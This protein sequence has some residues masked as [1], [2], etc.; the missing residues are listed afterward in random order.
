MVTIKFTMKKRFAFLT[1]ILVAFSNT[2]VYAQVDNN[3]S[4]ESFEKDLEEFRSEFNEFREKAVKE[5]DEYAKA[6][7]AEYME[8]VSS[9]KDMWGE[10]NVAED[11]KTEWV[12]YGKDLKSRSVVDFENGK[13]DV[14]ILLDDENENDPA[15][16]NQRLT[17]AIKDLLESRGTTCPYDSKV[18]KQ[19]PLSQTPILEGIVDFSNYNIQEKIANVD[20]SSNII[21]LKPKKKMPP[22]PV[23]KGK[24]LETSKNNITANTKSKAN[25]AIENKK[26]A[27][28]EE[29]RIAAEKKIKELEVE[30]I[31]EEKNVTIPAVN[32]TEQIAEV[33]AEQSV[34]SSTTIKGNDNK[35]RTI[36][37]IEMALVSDNLSKNA[38][39][40]K[41]YVKQYSQKFNIEQPLIFA[42][43]EQESSFNPK[44]KSWVPAYGL[45]QL[46]PT[47]GGYDAYRYVYKNDWVPTQS[48]L[49]VPHQNIELGTAYLRILMNQFAN[50]TNPDC[51][52]LCVIA[53]YNT[54]AGNVSRA[55]TGNTNIKKAIPLINKYSY[56]QLYQHLTN[57]LSTDEARKYVSGVS[58][59]REKYLK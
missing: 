59:R 50:V 14:E 18:D 17:T 6:M 28:L 37:K 58:K 22:T 46:V 48:Y 4:K 35:E 43:M 33:I 29:E 30:E 7:Y 47:S 10:E 31:E 21:D 27:K 15:I 38:T 52:R 5:Y 1:I 55:F 23:V 39:V 56:Q 53:S 8:Y 36:V 26:K 25:E 13:I 12:E 32:T 40:Y 51:R 45:M 49:Y 57:K 11:T 44:A 16:V 19:Q 54:G 41:D 2:T 34:K 42:V 3:V 20:N 24:T 9:I